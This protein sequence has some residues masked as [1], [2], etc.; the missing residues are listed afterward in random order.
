M[1]ERERET[2]VGSTFRFIFLFC[3][4]FQTNVAKDK[5]EFSLCCILC[6]VL[7][8]DAVRCGVRSAEQYERSLCLSRK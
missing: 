3:I 6:R 4:L 2:E 5:Q 7:L 1:T 8:R